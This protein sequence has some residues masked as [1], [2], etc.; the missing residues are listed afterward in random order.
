MKRTKELFLYNFKD[1]T[2]S[3]YFTNET[4]KLKNANVLTYILVIEVVSSVWRVA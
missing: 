1:N 4:A 3:G 2:I